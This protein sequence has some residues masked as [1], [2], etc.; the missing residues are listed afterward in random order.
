MKKKSKAQ[1]W[2]L[3][4]KRM[5]AYFI[6]PHFKVVKST[7]KRNCW[8]VYTRKWWQTSYVRSDTFY[9]QKPEDAVRYAIDKF[10][11]YYLEVPRKKLVIRRKK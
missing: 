9:R 2:K 8:F 4:V 6:C 5:I 1:I 11:G 10:K 3:R 7:K